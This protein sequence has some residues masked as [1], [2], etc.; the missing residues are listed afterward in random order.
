MAEDKDYR[1]TEYCPLLENVK[2]KKQALEEKIKS[3]CPRTKIFYNKIRDRKG[4]YHEKFAGIYNDKC[5]YCGVK[6]GLL[7]TESFEVDHFVNEASFPDSLEGRAEAGRVKNLVWACISCNHGKKG[8]TL[9]PP[10]DDILNPDNG[11]ITKVFWRD[12]KY[13]IHVCDTYQNDE[14]IQKFYKALGLGYEARRLDYLILQLNGKCQ[15]AKSSAQKGQLSEAL[16][17]LMQR[18]N[19]TKLTNGT[20][21]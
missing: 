19:R 1:N 9:I 21:T 6:W 4:A 12:K 13:N 16:N 14:M 18:R 2:E 11:N 3:E 20:L 10:Y 17:L 7:P 15:S 8:I 5:A